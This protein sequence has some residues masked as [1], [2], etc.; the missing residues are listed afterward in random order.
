MQPVQSPIGLARRARDPRRRRGAIYGWCA[1][2]KAAVSSD[3]AHA[4]RDGLGERTTPRSVSR[5]AQAC[6]RTLDGWHGI[7]VDDIKH[8]A[9]SGGITNMLWKFTPPPGRNL[10]QVAA[11]SSSG[12][13]G[14]S[15]PGPPHAREPSPGQLACCALV[16]GAGWPCVAGAPSDSLA[17][18]PCDRSPV[19]ARIFGENTELLI[20]R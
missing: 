4:G 20:D 8:E 3:L 15:R 7:D 5:R 10:R 1:R 14:P 19:C 9:I 16:H 12:G 17:R 18:T 11:R 6:V 13:A 2:A